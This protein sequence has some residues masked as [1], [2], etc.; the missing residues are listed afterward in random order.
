MG[1]VAIMYGNAY[2]L[3][4]DELVDEEPSKTSP[5]GEG[6]LTEGTNDRPPDV[7][8]LLGL[9]MIVGWSVFCDVLLVSF[10]SLVM[11]AQ[12]THRDQWE[13]YLP[14]TMQRQR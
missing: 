13:G 3:G 8:Q 6:Q 1:A 10:R 14:R 2:T 9:C 7:Q 4:F 12:S 5:C 11:R